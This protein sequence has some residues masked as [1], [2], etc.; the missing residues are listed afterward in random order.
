MLVADDVEP[1]RGE[2]RRLLV[3][4]DRHAQRMSDLAYDDVEIEIGG[5]E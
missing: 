1:V 3:D 4:I 2:L 5:S